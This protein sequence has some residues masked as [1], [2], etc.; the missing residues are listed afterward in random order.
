M[1]KLNVK[2]FGF[3]TLLLCTFS[4]QTIFADI[5]L[6]KDP[7]TGSAPNGVVIANS[8]KTASL[9]T[10]SII[11]VTAD[12]VNGELSVFF[13]YPVGIAQILVVDSTGAVVE[14]QVL[15]TNTSLDVYIPTTG[16]SSGNYTLKISYGTTH[17]SGDFQL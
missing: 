17:L 11:P 15:D 3:L 16:L 4:I 2:F 5:I 12:I 8:L 6:K 14:Y 10:Q 9:K 7:G 1:G 13:D